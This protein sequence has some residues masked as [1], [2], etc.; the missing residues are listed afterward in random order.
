MA[1]SLEPQGGKLVAWPQVL[2]R[3]IGQTF[4]ICTKTDGEKLVWQ[5]ASCIRIEL[6]QM[7]VHL[8]AFDGNA[9]A[10][11]GEREIQQ[12]GEISVRLPKYNVF[13]QLETKLQTRD[14]VT[15]PNFLY[16]MSTF[17]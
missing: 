11:L 13:H 17:P 7:I 14:Q 1:T 5:H 16:L 10:C 9:F 2:Y 4:L 6:E 3:Q 12:G 15:N 8:H